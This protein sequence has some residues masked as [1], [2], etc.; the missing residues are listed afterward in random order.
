VTE[1]SRVTVQN[2]EAYRQTEIRKLD[3]RHEEL[4]LEEQRVRLNL[5]DNEA[6]RMEINRQLNR[7]GQ[8]VDRMA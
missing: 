3:K 2:A 6:K 7:P 1:I 4:R 8:N 5:K